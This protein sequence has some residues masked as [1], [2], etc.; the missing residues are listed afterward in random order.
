MTAIRSVFARFG[1]YWLI[2][3]CGAGQLLAKVIEE[4]S[5]DF[6]VYHLAMTALL[7]EGGS[8]YGSYNA[9]PGMVFKYPPWIIPFF[10]PFGI[11]NFDVAKFAWG[12]VQL[13][14]IGYSAQWVLSRGK[15][16]FASFFALVSF[17]WI[18]AYHFEFGQFSLML[19]ATALYWEKNRSSQFRSTLMVLLFSSKIFTM[20][21]L[22]GDWRTLLRKRVVFWV[23]SSTFV[24]SGLVV[25]VLRYHGRDMSLVGLLQAWFDAAFSQNLLRNEI[26]RGAHNQ[27]FT[28]GLIRMLWFDSTFRF[29]E[30]LVFLGLVCVFVPFWHFASR[31][32]HVSEQWAGWLALGVI[33]HPLAWMHSY[34]FAFPVCGLALG[35]A[36]RVGKVGWVLTGFFGVLLVGLN[37]PH[38]NEFLESLCM[39]SWGVVL[40]MVTLAFSTESA[41]L[42]E[43]TLRVSG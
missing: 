7:K 42:A 28:A 4:Y 39:R 5:L 31:K 35:K 30:V 2:L 36:L 23:V 3:A 1:I 19:V 11:L 6:W 9:L 40:S 37:P 32:L 8:P 24:L 26:L 13:A 10:I 27:G 14:C 22:L 15:S 21:S 16:P 34:V 20:V 33:L 18:W 38:W 41:E 12:F 17:W 43:N 25:G 29:L